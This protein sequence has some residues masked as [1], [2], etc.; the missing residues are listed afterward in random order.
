MRILIVE[1]EPKV[2]SN[3]KKGLTETGYKVDI[4][5]NGEAAK[6]LFLLNTYGILIL[7]VILPDANGVELCKFFKAKKPEIKVIMLTALGTLDDKLKGFNAGADDY[8]PKPFEFLELIARIKSLHNRVRIENEEHTLLKVA[9]LSLDLKTKSASRSNVKIELTAKEFAL[10]EYLMRNKDKVV[11]RADIAEKVWDITFDTGTN[12][13][14][15]Y[16]NF[17]RKKIDK[18][19]D[20][21]LLHTLIG[22]GYILREKS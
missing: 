17:L 9:D 7:D 6:T 12:V 4:A 5:N 19:H 2:A 18:N 20:I 3:L 14:D 13:I 1:D 15:V 11:S 10:L 16:I 21:K 8:L 22:M